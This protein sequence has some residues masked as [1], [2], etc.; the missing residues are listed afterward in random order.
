[1][2]RQHLKTFTLCVIVSLV[3]TLCAC[4]PGPKA[5]T[6]ASD[7]RT[8]AE[9]AEYKS[10]AILSEEDSHAMCGGVWISEYRAITAAH[11]VADIGKPEGD[12]A[13]EDLEEALGMPVPEYSPVGQMSHYT[14]K[15]G[16]YSDPVRSY[17]I[18][19]IR[20]DSHADLA[21]LEVQED[22][23]G[24]SLMPDHGIAV[25]ETG[26]MRD[27]DEMIIVGSMGAIPFTVSYGRLAGI[28]TIGDYKFVQVTGPV[29]F[30]NSG[31]GIFGPDGELYSLADF[32]RGDRSGPIP[33]LVFGQHP[34]TI[35]KF[36]QDK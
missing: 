30:G 15:A 18:K 28:R 6:V 21:L 2:N 20:F 19:V 23:G 10:I 9:I 1:M 4:C 5:P 12:K 35:R 24:F 7:S 8:A 16:A 14:D 11:C 17:A 22:K 27:G 29:W 33:G 26:H 34:D 3:S 31:G 13:L 25:V 32:M 36:L